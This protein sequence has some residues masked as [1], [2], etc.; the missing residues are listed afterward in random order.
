MQ[1]IESGQC[2]LQQLKRS[3][4]AEREHKGAI[5][6]K[7]PGILVREFT[8]GENAKFS[9]GFPRSL[10]FLEVIYFDRTLRS[11]FRG[12]RGSLTFETTHFPQTLLTRTVAHDLIDWQDRHTVFEGVSLESACS[13][14]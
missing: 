6:S 14:S 3:S 2:P 11:L 1:F 12:A 5:V 9:H 7:L 8:R 10:F 4:N 13:A